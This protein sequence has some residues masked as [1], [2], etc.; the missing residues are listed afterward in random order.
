LI[1][2]DIV[3]LPYLGGVSILHSTGRKIQP[4]K[5]DS[6]AHLLF[7]VRNFLTCNPYPAL[8]DYFLLL[9]PSIFQSNLIFFLI[10]FFVKAWETGW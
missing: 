1:S 8:N 9:F 6:N 7:W 4:M 10:R 5:S 2:L 3:D